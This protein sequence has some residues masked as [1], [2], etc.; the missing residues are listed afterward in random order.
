MLLCA[1]GAW[2]L[3]VDD[4]ILSNVRPAAGEIDGELRTLENITFT[5][6][7]DI[8]IGPKALV[9]LTT[10]DDKT[11]EA[12]PVASRFWKNICAVDFP[13][14]LPYNGT[15]KLVIK[16]WSVGDAE[17]LAN[18]EA[19]HS[20]PEIVL[21]WTVVNGLE[22]GADY[23]IVPV[24]VSPENNA[25]FAYNNGQALAQIKL[26]YPNGTILNP[27]AQIGLECVEARFAQ[28][29]T[30][31]AKEGAENTTFTA[32]VS[33]VPIASGRYTLTIPA[34][35]FGD[36]DYLSGEG[37]HANPPTTFMYAV[38]GVEDDEGELKETLYYTLLPAK[39]ALTREENDYRYTMEWKEMPD[40]N[41]RYVV[42]CKV[43]DEFGYPVDTKLT[44]TNDAEAKTSVFSF[45]A[46][47]EQDK[48]YR[49]LIMP[50]IFSDA[51]YAESNKTLGQLNPQFVEKFV[52]AELLKGDDNGQN[53]VEVVSTS[54]K[55]QGIYNL[56]GIEVK[57][58]QKGIFIIE[59]KKVM[60]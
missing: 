41:D 58:P 21:E 13:D 43:I 56:Q 28:T 55:P 44:L 7:Q 48:P 31:W 3:P 29:L 22:P 38:S 17:W 57:N 39:A 15:Y 12:V 10:P 45:T 27:N 60:K 6:N 35:A 23:D 47:L 59:G 26:E 14:F 33:P 5:F 37:G 24:S 2:A 1:A 25:Q 20:N 32:Q 36:A 19:G 54:Y 16:R 9:T 42:Q 53:G 30:F 34:G 18:R 50:A 49:L 4:V 52:P 40:V 46:E 51:K 11:Y 8:E